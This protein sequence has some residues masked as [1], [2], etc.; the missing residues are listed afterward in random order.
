MLQFRNLFFLF[1]LQFVNK[2]NC[3]KIMKHFNHTTHIIP[4]DFLK[5]KYV[6]YNKI[7]AQEG[8]SPSEERLLKYL[9]KDYN[10]QIMPRENLNESFKLYVGLAMGQ[11]IN[12][13]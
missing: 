11:L 6:K 5:D 10:P 1:L 12:I 4:T 9:F 7:K 8:Y 3:A 13:V 2:L